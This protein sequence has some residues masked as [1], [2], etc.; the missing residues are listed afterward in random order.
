[1]HAPELRPPLPPFDLDSAILKVRLAE[2]GWNSRDPERV[3][4]AYTEDSQWRNRAEFPRGR[5][6]II[7]FLSRKWR[8]EHEYRLIKELWA[9]DR[10]RIAVRFAYEWRDEAGQWFRSYGNENWEFAADG[11]MQRRYACINDL[12]IR[13]D[14]RLFHWPLGRRP[15][16]HPGLSELGL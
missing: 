7:E 3:A 14:E 13:E 11:L 6:Q 8:R 15:E 5:A 9:H 4:Q 10:E 2:D 12:A 1:M 16:D